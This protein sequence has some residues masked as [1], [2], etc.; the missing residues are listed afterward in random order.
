MKTVY[1]VRA[2]L[3]DGAFCDLILFARRENAMRHARKVLERNADIL[4]IVAVE[5]V[6]HVI[7][8]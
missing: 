5:I 7:H 1:G 6:T 2:H 4:G 8:P 3:K